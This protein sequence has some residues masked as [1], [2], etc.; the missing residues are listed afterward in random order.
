MLLVCGECLVLG[1][2]YCCWVYCIV[3]VFVVVLVLY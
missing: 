2:F 3:F 1:D